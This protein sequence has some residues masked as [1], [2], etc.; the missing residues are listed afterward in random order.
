M[1]FKHHIILFGRTLSLVSAGL[2]CLVLCHCSS[3]QRQAE[4]EQYLIESEREWAES[5]ATG[6]TSVIE[7]ILA[8]DFVGVAPK[9]HSYDKAKMISDTRESPKY[10]VSDRSEE[11]TSEL[12]SQSNLVC[13]LLLEKKKQT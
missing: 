4:W 11:H 10:F 2:P 5:V 7:R 13:R 1:S 3:A 8:D 9:G 6:D 12:Q